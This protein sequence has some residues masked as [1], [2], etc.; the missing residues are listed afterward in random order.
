MK[1]VQS[2]FPQATGMPV[3]QIEAGKIV[4]DSFVYAFIFS[5]FVTFLYLLII[6]R[7]IY[8]VLQC[9]GSLLIAL[10]LL[11]F[12]MIIFKINLNFANMIS[13]PL[14]FSLGISYPIYFLRRYSEMKGT[15]KVF[16]SNTPLAILTSSLTTIASFGTL[17]L[18]SHDGTS[19]MGL[20]LFLSLLTT[21][22]SSLVF[23]PIFTSFIKSR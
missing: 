2:Q 9:I 22:I 14:L 1:S 4:V 19:S 13:L 5:F 18:S 3:V 21:L 7:K 17:Y 20:L 16:N 15:I 6:F 10:T 8:Y 11:I 12:L 23:L